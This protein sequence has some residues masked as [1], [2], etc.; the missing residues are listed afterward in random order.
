MEKRERSIAL[1]DRSGGVTIAKQVAQRRLQALFPRFDLRARQPTSYQL[2]L[3]R[4][5]D[6]LRN[7]IVGIV[8]WREKEC[9]VDFRIRASSARSLMATLL[10][11]CGYC[12]YVLGICGIT[13]L[14]QVLTRE[15]I[16][17]F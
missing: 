12:T 9:N 17:N 10:A 15:N 3:D 2:R 4:M 16:R 13:S 6:E 8:H 11:F 1:H 7:Q 5:T 14:R